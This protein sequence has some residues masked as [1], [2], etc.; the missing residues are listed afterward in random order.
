LHDTIED[1]ETTIEEL[2]QEFG[3]RIAGI[4]YL[5]FSLKN[6]CIILGIVAELTDDKSLD[7][8]ERKRLQIVNANKLTP[9]AIIVRLADKISNLRDLNRITPVG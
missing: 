4:L 9:D 2:Q 5:F 7:K 1:T 3:T 6:L 8:V